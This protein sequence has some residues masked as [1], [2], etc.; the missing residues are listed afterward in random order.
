[1]RV[2]FRAPEVAMPKKDPENPCP[3]QFRPF[4]LKNKK[5]ELYWLV[6]IGDTVAK[7]QVICEGEVEKKVVELLS[8][9]DGI[10]AE[11]CVEEEGTFR[12]GDLL[13]II[14]A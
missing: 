1:M 2:E 11:I 5:G 10:L 9:C 7:D 14:E 6:D 3:C 4:Q 8:P 13:G 12:P